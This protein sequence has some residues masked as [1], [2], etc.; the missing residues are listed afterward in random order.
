MIVTAADISKSALRRKA[1]TRASEEGLSWRQ[2]CAE[3][4]LRLERGGGAG[5]GGWGGGS[6]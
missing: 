1:V 5:G 6:V 4:G 2:K 3:M